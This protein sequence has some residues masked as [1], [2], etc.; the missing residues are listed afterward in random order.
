MTRW[1]RLGRRERIVAPQEP[2]PAGSGLVLLLLAGASLGAAG[3]IVSY[4]LDAGTQLLGVSIGVAFACLGAAAITAGKRL[5]PEEEEEEE[6]PERVHAE[7]R[8]ESI[9]LVR[10]S[11]EGVSRRRLL[12]AATGGTMGVVGAALVLPAASLGPGAGTETL[13]RTPWRAGRRLV[14]KHGEAISADALEVGSFLTAFPDAGEPRALD[15]SVIVVRLRPEEVDLAPERADW[16]PEGIVAY[17]KSCTHA[18]CAV[19][20]FRHPRFDPTSPEPRLVCPC[21]YSVF[22]PGRGGSVR[23][24]PA[25]RPLPQLPLRLMDD[26]TL[27]AAGELSGPPGP[28]WAGVRR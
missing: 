16:A 21:H 24:G 4:I 6:V 27:A 2:D 15:A 10:E 11:G 5:V 20:L 22:D 9:Q 12:F 1:L 28:T 19:S 13:R 3:F 25:G 26:R 23:G 8:L 7:E 14:D 18:A 17:S